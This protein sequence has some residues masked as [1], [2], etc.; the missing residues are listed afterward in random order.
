MSHATGTVTVRLMG[1]PLDS[2]VR[3]VPALDGQPPIRVGFPVDP[4]IEPPEVVYYRPTGHA[5]NEPGQPDAYL[6]VLDRDITQADLD[7]ARPISDERRR[8]IREANGAPSL[9][10]ISSKLR[11]R[12][13]PQDGRQV[14]DCDLRPGHTLVMPRITDEGL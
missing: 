5:W 8:Q 3:Q 10:W 7:T 4:A 1:G 14:A 6:Y 12:G 13:G 2:Q 9:S 11:L